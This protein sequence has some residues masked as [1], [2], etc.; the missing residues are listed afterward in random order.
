[1]AAILLTFLGEENHL[2]RGGCNMKNS[3]ATVCAMFSLLLSPS[4]HADGADLPIN[5]IDASPFYNCELAGSMHGMSVAVFFGGEVISGPGVLSCANDSTKQQV[6]I[7][8][9][10][11]LLGG[12]VGFDFSVIRNIAVHTA[13]IRV[14]NPASLVQTYALGATAGVTL[15]N[16]GVGFD[17]AASLT[18]RQGL[19]FEVGFTG[20]DAVG[21]GAHLF[22]MT[23]KIERM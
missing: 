5:A 11:S 6:T 7:P 12:G 22:A 14:F 18:G 1:L 4:S 2:S 23:F 21:L 3:I 10:L 13:N 9:K 19:G 20:E 17:V 8:V 16:A 15:V